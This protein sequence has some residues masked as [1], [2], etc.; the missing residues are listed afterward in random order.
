MIIIGIGNMFV[1]FIFIMN[2]HHLKPSIYCIFA[3]CFHD[4]LFYFFHVQFFFMKR[5]SIHFALIEIYTLLLAEI[6]VFF[7]C[8]NN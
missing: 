2:N 8:Y 5:L 1:P 4:A 6:S 3:L 7:T